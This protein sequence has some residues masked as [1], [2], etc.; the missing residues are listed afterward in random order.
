MTNNTKNSQYTWSAQQGVVVGYKM[1]VEFTITI[2][3][4][5]GFALIIYNR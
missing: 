2:F 5:Y 4:I 3:P 1:L